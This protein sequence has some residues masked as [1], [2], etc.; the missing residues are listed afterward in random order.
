MINSGR[1]LYRVMFC[2]NDER[3]N[4]TGRVVEL[5]IADE[6]HL[7]CSNDRG[8]SIRFLFPAGVKVGRRTF[9][10]GDRQLWVG[11]VFWDSFSMTLGPARELVAYLIASGWVVEGAADDGPFADL[12]KDAA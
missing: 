9:G 10:G 8:L 12:A 4:F 11:N 1:P 7:R 5:D 3:G 2:C 6:V